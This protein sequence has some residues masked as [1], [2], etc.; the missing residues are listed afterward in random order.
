MLGELHGENEIPA[1]VRSL[2][3]SMWKTGY[4]YV[5]AEISPWAANR[6][7][8]GSNVPISGLWTQPEAT[9]VT[10]LKRDRAAVLWGCDIEEAQ[11]HFLIRE[12]AAENPRSKDL[13]AAAEM[14]KSGYQRRMAPAL[15]Q[16]V[17]AAVGATDRLIG[18]VSLQ[19]SLLR[20]LEVESDRFS[21]AALSASVRRERVMKD[22]LHRY[23][24]RTDGAK[25]FLRFGRNHLHRGIDRRGISTL[26]N[27]VA[28][29]AEAK[30]MRAFNVAAFAGGGKIQLPGRAIDFDERGDDPAFAYL[31]S[32]ARYPATVFDLRPM[33]Q[34]LH[35]LP[36]NK[37]SAIEASLVYWADSYDAIIF[38]REVTP[39]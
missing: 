25:V 23:Y 20:T 26:G 18:G 6:L 3:P 29:L 19:N 24:M 39:L 37:R 36:A 32:I 17:Q 28:E 34:P 7:E 9:F 1:L 33:R 22:L 2:W 38:Y 14:V 27:F 30:G 10:S 35:R 8:F 5:A 15:L 21:G 11:P 12:L 13:Q 16:L 4:R 31:A